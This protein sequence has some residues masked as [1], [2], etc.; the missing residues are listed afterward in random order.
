MVADKNILS[1]DMQALL[2]REA[3]RQ[4]AGIIAR[5]AEFLAEEMIEGVLYDRGGP[6][7]LRL[8]A[9]IIRVNGSETFGVVGHA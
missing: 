7:A 1:D 6:N 3:M 8:M 9:G 4:A 2:Q 5:Q